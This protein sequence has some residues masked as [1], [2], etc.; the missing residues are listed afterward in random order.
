V[1][2][3]FLPAALAVDLG[4]LADVRAQAA[5]VLDA[6]DEMELCQAAA[7]LS[8]AIDSLDRVAEEVGLRGFRD[9]QDSGAEKGTIRDQSYVA[10]MEAH[11]QLEGA[12]PGADGDA[13]VV[14]AWDQALEAGD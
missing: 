4:R 6:L 1:S 7:Y 11:G 3:G 9:G 5:G 12:E 14:G 13:R 10:A 2:G 8:M